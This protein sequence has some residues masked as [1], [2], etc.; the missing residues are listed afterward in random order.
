MVETAG[1]RDGRRPRA[2]FDVLDEGDALE[3]V[4][5]T[6]SRWAAEAALWRRN[7]TD[8]SGEAG[9]GGTQGEGGPGGD[10]GRLG[11]VERPWHHHSKECYDASRVCPILRP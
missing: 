1:S 10:G 6:L 3:A 5:S 9:G 7:E 2:H 11:R 4:A 8:D